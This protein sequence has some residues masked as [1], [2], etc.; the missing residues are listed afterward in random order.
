MFVS[1]CGCKKSLRFRS[2]HRTSRSVCCLSAWRFAFH[3]FLPDV[4]WKNSLLDPHP[5]S[6]TQSYMQSTCVLRICNYALKQAFCNMNETICAIVIVGEQHYGRNLLL[7]EYRYKWLL[8]SIADFCLITRW[9]IMRRKVIT[10][11]H[12][13]ATINSRNFSICL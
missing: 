10:L 11:Q 1:I 5:L 8:G 12:I 13:L 2:S 3:F 6:W 7:C 9:R 4:Q